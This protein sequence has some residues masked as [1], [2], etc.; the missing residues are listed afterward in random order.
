MSPWLFNVCIDERGENG[1]GEERD[2]ERER[3]RERERVRE[4]VMLI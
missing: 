4:T 1:D 3:E 2:R